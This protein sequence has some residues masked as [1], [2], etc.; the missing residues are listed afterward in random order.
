MVF[1]YFFK[2][3]RQREIGNSTKKRVGSAYWVKHTPHKEL[4]NLWN[5]L[6]RLRIQ[7]DNSYNR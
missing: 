4:W 3:R 5:T 6:I 1:I 7:N 2:E